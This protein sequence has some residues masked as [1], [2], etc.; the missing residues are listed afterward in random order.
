[1]GDLA[2]TT[3]INLSIIPL[4]F[5]EFKEFSAYIEA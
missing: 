5:V 2:H 4:T 1:M 3:K